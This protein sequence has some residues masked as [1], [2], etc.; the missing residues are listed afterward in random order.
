M[1]RVNIR[2]L[3]ASTATLV[4]ATG[5][6]ATRIGAPAPFWLI[7]KIPPVPVANVRFEVPTNT[8]DA[9]F[10]HVPSSQN[11]CTV[12]VTGIVRVETPSVVGGV[13]PVIV[14]ADVTCP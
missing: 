7:E 8:A 14:V 3:R 10:E 6:P 2:F 13:A 12:T 4:P 9:V 5:P 1:S 11:A